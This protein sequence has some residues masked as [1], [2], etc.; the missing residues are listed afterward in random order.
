MQD[1]RIQPMSLHSYNLSSEK[2]GSVHDIFKR[3]AALCTHFINT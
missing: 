3:L 2:N 1:F